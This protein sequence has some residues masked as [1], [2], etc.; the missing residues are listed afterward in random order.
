[1]FSRLSSSLLHQCTRNQSHLQITRFAYQAAVRPPLLM[2][3]SFGA[4]ADARSGKT[5]HTAGCV[6]IGD[7]VLGGKTVDTNSGYFAKY[8]FSLGI[9]L[10]RIEVI[11][12]DEAEIIEATRRMSANYDLVVTSGGIGP[13]HD[14]ITYPSIAKGFGLTLKLH[15]EAFAR[16]KRLSRPHHS[17]L[18]FSWDVPSPTLTAKLR[19]VELPTDES[20]GLEA[21]ALFVDDQLWVPIS[22]VNENIFILPGVPRLFEQLLR[23][24][25]PLLLPRLADPEGRGVYR[26]MVSTPLAESSIAPF[27]TELAKK[28]EYRGVKVGSYPQWNSKT[29]TVT[30]VGKDRPFMESLLP[31]LEKG[32]QGK[33][34]LVEGNEDPDAKK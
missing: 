16:M 6:I 2:T 7:E 21:Q 12:D 17:Q 13:T 8:C 27:L 19:M 10:K 32:I 1:M 9:D 34:V 11:A 22:V 3:S 33:R 15:E 23:G 25:K 31:E 24:L 30:L 26:V 29:N 5:I 4:S 14:D 18:N 28:V 20:R